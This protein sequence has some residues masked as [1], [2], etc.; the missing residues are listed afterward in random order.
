M[1]S[2]KKRTDTIRLT[3]SG[4]HVIAGSARR[5]SLIGEVNFIVQASRVKSPHGWML[6]AL[7]TTRTLDTALAEVLSFKQWSVTQPNLRAYLS[8]LH[9]EGVLSAAE[10]SLYRARIVAPRNRYLHQAGSFPSQLDAEALLV[11]MQICLAAV[12]AQV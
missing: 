7:Y 1:T 11:D 10:Y 2:T 12:L 6:Q 5:N 8:K 3:L 9:T 4:N